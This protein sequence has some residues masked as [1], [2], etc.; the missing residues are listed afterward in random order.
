MVSG[1]V[2]GVFP[3]HGFTTLYHLVRKHAS[4]PHAEAAMDRL[5]DRL[6]I[7]NLDAD[8]WRE[9]RRLEFED[10]KDA[11]VA[12]VA[13]KHRSDFIISRNIDDFAHSPVPVITPTDFLIEFTLQNQ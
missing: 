8:G 2:A 6:Q 1:Q 3:S 9:A 11:V 10:F 13:K 4:K 5:L 7:G 12:V